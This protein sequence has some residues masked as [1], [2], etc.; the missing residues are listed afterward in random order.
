MTAAPAKYAPDD[1]R[2]KGGNWG[3]GSN[4]IRRTKRLRIYAR[5]GWRCVWCLCKV[6]SGCS[7]PGPFARE[8]TR[9]ATLDHVLTRERGGTNEHTNLLTSCLSCNSERGN[10]SALAYAYS[11]FRAAAPDVMARVIEATGKDLP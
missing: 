6:K 5:D 8:T 7:K 3:Q 4:W 9:I 11:R 2:D 1:P 10:L